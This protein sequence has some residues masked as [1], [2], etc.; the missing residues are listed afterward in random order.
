[1]KAELRDKKMEINDLHTDSETLKNTLDQRNIELDKYRG[2]VSSLMADS[3][4]LEG[5]RIALVKQLEE[6]RRYNEKLKQ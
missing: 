3:D 4:E 6:I 5:E 2:D 1:M